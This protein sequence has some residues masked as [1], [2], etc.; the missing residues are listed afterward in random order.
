MIG[1]RVAR[2][3]YRVTRPVTFDGNSRLHALRHTLLRPII[4]QP[5]FFLAEPNP[6]PY[7]SKALAKP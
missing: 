4:L 5:E 1:I 7:Y 3:L 6:H 2:S